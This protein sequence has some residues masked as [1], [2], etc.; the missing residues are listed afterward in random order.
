[1]A[2]YTYSGD[3]SSSPMDAVRFWIQ[4][5]ASPWLA[6]NQEIT[7]VLVNYPNPILAA[8]Q[9][10]RSIATKFANAVNKR[11]GDLSINYSDKSKAYLAMAEQF[12]LQGVMSG[13]T[14]YAGGISLSDMQADVQ[15]T[16][17][18]RPPF[19]QDQFDIPPT[20][21]YSTPYG[22]QTSFWGPIP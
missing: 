9:M 7:Y 22:D 13:L 2:N 14:P 1:M 17:K 16:D 10:C 18:V 20:G 21:P 8:A 11:V 3:P 15:N 19:Y 12:D 6:S 5:T 4:D